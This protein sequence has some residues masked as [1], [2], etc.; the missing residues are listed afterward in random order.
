M[1]P[2]CSCCRR[3][4]TCVRERAVLKSTRLTSVP[5]WPVILASALTSAVGRRARVWC[6]VCVGIWTFLGVNPFRCRR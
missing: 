2:A 5:R 1:D 3:L 4:F 6:T